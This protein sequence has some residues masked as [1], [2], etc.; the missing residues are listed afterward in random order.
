MKIYQA[1]SSK[2]GDNFGKIKHESHD[3]SQD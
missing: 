2:K 1:T 3:I